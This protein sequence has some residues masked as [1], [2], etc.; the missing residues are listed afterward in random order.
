MAKGA[1]ATFFAG[2]II[3][4]IKQMLVK[5][6]LKIEIGTKTNFCKINIQRALGIN[7]N[8]HCTHVYTNIHPVI[9]SNLTKELIL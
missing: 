2:Y 4:V 9:E 5:L 7:H 8:I 6:T 1:G 3:E